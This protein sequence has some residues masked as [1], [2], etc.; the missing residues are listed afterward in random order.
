MIL[1]IP[2]LTTWADGPPIYLDQWG[3]VSL[4]TGVT[5]DGAGDVYA[6]DATFADNRI[7]KFDGNGNPVGNRSI[8]G[9]FTALTSV[10]V[11]SAG[12]I[13]VTD[14]NPL[15]SH[16]WKL[17]SITGTGISELESGQFTSPTGVA[18]DGANNIYVADQINHRIQK[19]DSSGDFLRM[20]G[21]GVDTGA[22]TFQICTAGC[23][24]GIAGSGTGQFDHPFDVA[25]DS[26][27]NVYVVDSRNAR[28]Q[29]FDSNGTFL[30]MWGFGVSTGAAIFEICTSS[31]QIGVS[32]S[33][34]GQFS[35]SVSVAGGGVGVDGAD[36]VYVTD[37]VLHR[38][39][40]SSSGGDF[41][42][43]WGTPGNGNG[44]FQG[45]SDV[46]ISGVDNI[47]VADESNNRIQ[48]FGQLPLLLTKTVD[49]DT[50]YPGQGITYTIT[51]DNN[52]AISATNVVISDTLPP[53]LEIAGPVRLEGTDGITDSPPT[54]ASG[55][56]I[57]GG[58]RITVTLPVTVKTGLAYNTIITNT[59]SVTSDQTVTPQTDSHAITV[60]IADLTLIKAVSTN[61]FPNIA[62]PGERI[63]YTVSVS[64]SGPDDATNAVIS[65][66]LPGGLTFIGPVN[67]EGTGGITDSPP[68]LASGLTISAG[69]SITL[70][71]PVTVNTDQD[72]GAIII[73]TAAVTSAEVTSPITDPELIVVLDTI[74]P[75]FPISY[76]LTGSPLITPTLG[77]ILDNVRPVFE[78]Y[79][80]WDNGQV[81]TYF[82]T[83]SS[84]LDS[85][86]LLASDSTISTTQTSFI[87][88]VDL[89]NGVYTW[90]VRVY[91]AAGNT[92]DLGIPPQ[93]FS[94]QTNNPEIYLPIIMKN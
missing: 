16:V 28:V 44:E 90:T 54:L 24:A 15:G 64:N 91:D 32:G 5:V 38:I 58:T 70:T 13:Y 1:I 75:T 27:N 12:N 57:T 69:A 30:R 89:P 93:T 23:Q 82:L 65:D 61:I 51:V 87:P 67:L 47:Y 41:L 68:L 88:T 83:L 62:N 7:R 76:P 46:A 86:G 31:C 43:K 14:A 6:I 8:S 26:A 52:S 2:P 3:G 40:K 59:A 56:T 53:E 48:K 50:P 37:R 20:W 35:V 78:W 92:N 84:T 66:T 71:F 81:L 60:K 85:I 10:A 34:D 33:G 21:F 19:Y 29:K 25:V 17:D 77:V 11:D 55:M 42:T 18:V 22:N 79:A 4:P 49:D 9:M 72:H 45:P 80:A 63:T 74:S 36:N 73:N 39:Q 94:I